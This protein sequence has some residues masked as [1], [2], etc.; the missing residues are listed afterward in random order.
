MSETTDVAINFLESQL[1]SAKLRLMNQLDRV[2]DEV[3][4]CQREMDRDQIPTHIRSM[5]AF[6]AEAIEIATKVQ[7]LTEALGVLKVKKP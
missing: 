5:E 2:K 3:V 7:V 6:A 4:V 1:G